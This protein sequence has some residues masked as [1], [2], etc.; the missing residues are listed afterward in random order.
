VTFPNKKLLLLPLFPEFDKG[1]GESH[2]TR[3]IVSST[4]SPFIYNKNSQFTYHYSSQYQEGAKL[5]HTTAQSHADFGVESS[6]LKEKLDIIID[7]LF[8]G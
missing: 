1:R 6:Q 3:Q 7:T 4:L 2:F 5:Q 8:Q